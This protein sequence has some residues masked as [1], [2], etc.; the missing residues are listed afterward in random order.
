MLPTLR[1][2]DTESKAQIAYTSATHPTVSLYTCGPTIYNFP[3]IG[4]LRTF[5]FEDVLK[6]A[7]K[8]FGMKV[9]H[10][11]N[12][13][14]IDDKTI[15]GA[16]VNKC[17]LK[18]F[19]DPYKQAFF[20]DI[21]TLSFDLAD[22][23][24]AATDYVPQ[25]IAMIETLIKKGYAYVAPD[26]SV[27]FSIRKFKDYGRLSHFKLD[28]LEVGAS[29]RVAA[30]E[31]Q[32]EN[33]SDFVLWKSYDATCD[34]PVHYPS[35]WGQGRPGW[36]I[37]CSAMA[38]S[39]LGNTV[40]IHCGG[41]DNMFPHH[42]N[43][44][45][46][47][48]CCTGHKFVKHWMHAEH[49]LVDGKKMSKSLGN[50]YTLRDILKMGHT[51]ASVRYLLLSTHYRGNLNFTLDG[52]VAA[53]TA[54]ARIRGFWQRMED[55]AN[56][57]D[58]TAFTSHFVDNAEK[59]FFE[60]IADDLNTSSALAALFDCITTGNQMAD[61]KTLGS[62]GAASVLRFL[63]KADQIFACLA[64]EQE[65]IPAAIHDLAQ[66]RIEARKAKNFAV[67]DSLRDELAAAG[68]AME[69][70]PTGYKL[71]KI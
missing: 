48:E 5:A 33:A 18:E 17:S 12:L 7:L 2:F 31:Y 42:E 24:P 54:L 15:R 64:P 8:L 47:S 3:H 52:L 30:D 29:Q 19:T 40:D 61:S 16:V 35:P 67:S 62:N 9:K 70:S 13:T 38:T 25:M 6:R 53:K 37:E 34:G 50:F 11:Q 51:G 58:Q 57:P 56:T 14:D 26:N 44:I 55:L 20:E 49:L 23:Y 65:V 22:H 71:K 32:K 43:E 39:L 66:R 28:E 69:D 21:K 68:Y 10:V 59:A 1:L 36:H 63:K 46:Q 60:A 4:N 41:V 45:A 27:Y